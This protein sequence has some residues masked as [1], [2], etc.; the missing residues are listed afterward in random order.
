MLAVATMISTAIAGCDTG[1]AVS[2][3]SR[4]PDSPASSTARLRASAK[5][6]PALPPRTRSVDPDARKA[7]VA[8]VQWTTTS[9]GRQLQVFPTTAGRTDV[10]P[11]AARRAWAEI[12]AHAP[13]AGTAGMYDQFLCHWNFARVVEPA[14]PSWNLEPWRPAVG[15]SATVAALCNP[16]GSEG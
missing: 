15:Y 5:V 7:L 10:F 6:T 14:K 3:Q 13:N 4:P 11:T 12:L 1:S 9:K 2:R 8:R 16:G